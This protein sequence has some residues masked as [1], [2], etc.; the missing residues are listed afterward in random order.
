MKTKWTDVA[1]ALVAV[2]VGLCAV[3]IISY[4][5]V[6]IWESLTLQI[7][8]ILGFIAFYA[9]WLIA[10]WIGHKNGRDLHL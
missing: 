8:T 3:I 9:V 4:A 5:V 1:F 10:A 2:F 6:L 7:V